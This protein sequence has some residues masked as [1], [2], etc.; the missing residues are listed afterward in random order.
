MVPGPVVVR[1]AGG[2]RDAPASEGAPVRESTDFAAPAPANSG[3]DADAA[4]AP[5]VGAT[6]VR[7]PSADATPVRAPPA[8]TAPERAA[9]ATAPSA[10]AA[11]RRAASASAVS[12]S[13]A[14][15]RATSASAAPARP[16]IPQAVSALAPP[17]QLTPSAT[18]VPARTTATNKASNA[19]AALPARNAN[20]PFNAS[21]SVAAASLRARSPSPDCQASPAARLRRRDCSRGSLESAAARSTRAQAKG[22]SPASRACC[23]AVRSSAVSRTLGPS[24][25]APRCQERRGVSP[26]ARNTRASNRWTSRRS[27]GDPVSYA[28]I[29]VHASRK[30]TPPAVACATPAVSAA[31]RGRVSSRPAAT[32]RRKACVATGY[33]SAAA[34]SNSRRVSS[35][36]AR[37]SRRYRVSNSGARDA[38]SVGRGSRP[39]AWRGVRRGR[40]SAAARGSP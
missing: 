14:S 18:L 29:L 12:A 11:S 20:T 13:P 8:G 30:T 17:P 10:R 2:V 31:S 25:P 23:A 36:R 5:S 7:G 6:S 40:S 32:A 24:A 39:A 34:S 37:I 15:L 3:A 4:R 38:G 16:A 35:G 22:C 21:L 26:S 33:W 1:S 27:A 9:S 19:S 28:A